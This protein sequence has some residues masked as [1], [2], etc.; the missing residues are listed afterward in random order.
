MIQDKVNQL[1]GIGAIVARGVQSDYEKIYQKERENTKFVVE[2]AF[3]GDEEGKEEALKFA[4]IDPFGHRDIRSL[5]QGIANQKAQQNEYGKYENGAPATS[6]QNGA[7]T[8]VP[9]EEA[10]RMK[11]IQSMQEKGQSSF[12][13]NQE[14][15]KLVDDLRS[16]KQISHSAY[17]QFKE[18]TKNG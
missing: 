11:G 2:G 9:Q 1:L 6:S 12:N 16:K 3:K 18:A 17:E 10:G 15:R 14:L 5:K 8:S 7:V 13:Q 4:T